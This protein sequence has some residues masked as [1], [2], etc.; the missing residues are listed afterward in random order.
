MGFAGAGQP[1][2]DNIFLVDELEIEECQDAC[3]VDEFW[4]KGFCHIPRPL[5]YWFSLPTPIPF[6]YL[7]FLMIAI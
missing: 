1:H 4:K 3:L 7:S 2:E 6:T 5:P